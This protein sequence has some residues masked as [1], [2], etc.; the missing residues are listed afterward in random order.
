VKTNDQAP[1][2]SRA[3]LFLSGRYQ[4][5]RNRSPVGVGSRVGKG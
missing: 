4:T 1:R 2:Y 5:H 3:H